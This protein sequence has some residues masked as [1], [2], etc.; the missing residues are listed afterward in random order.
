M[1]NMTVLL[2]SEDPVLR[3]MIINALEATKHLQ[4][5][6]VVTEV[7][8]LEDA[9]WKLTPD[10][11]VATLG[12]DPE[13][14]LEAL[15]SL[16]ERCPEAIL[17]G[18][19]ERSDL[20]IRSMQIGVREY[21]PL[22]IEPD[23]FLAVMERV[24]SARGPQKN[25]S[26]GQIISI[27]GAK[28]GVGTTTIACQVASGLQALGAKT[29]I[30]DLNLISGDVAL[31]HDMSPT[32][33]VADLERESGEIDKTY[34]QSLIE[35]HESGVGLMAS[36]LHVHAE[37]TVRPARLQQALQ[38]IQDFNDFVLIDLPSDRGDLGMASLEMTDQVL[39]VT[40]LDVPSLAHCK[41]ELR[42]VDQAGVPRNSTLVV[43]NN[44]FPDS[45]LSAKDIRSFLGRPV[46]FEIP[47]DI[48]TV[49]EAI[50][51]GT[52]V[53]SISPRSDIALAIKS[54]ASELGKLSGWQSEAEGSP[55]R[56][57]SKVRKLILGARYGTS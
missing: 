48:S 51:K 9:A 2:V 46:D 44:S 36:P 47:R 19:A 3:G 38:L 52:A 50:N 28:G 17:C 33:G 15:A 4:L 24:S 49:M 42:R 14:I 27:L 53:S 29:V 41:L 22:P 43:A 30:I 54:M 1:E 8:L 5:E 45:S 25:Q 55:S 13:S 57:M 32:F 18:P 20:I 21:V 26:R 16:G 34:L 12:E 35:I 37:P 39:V 40:S 31:Y 6:E 11:I 23:A 10:L 56:A 7:S